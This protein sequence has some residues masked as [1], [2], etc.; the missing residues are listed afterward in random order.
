MRPPNTSSLR[1]TVPTF[2]FSL[3]TT[4]GCIW[5]SAWHPS[6]KL[7]LRDLQLLERHR[8][9]DDH[10]ALRRARDAA[11]DDQEVVLRI[12][13][14]DLQVVNR[15]ALAA[16]AAGGAHALDHPRRERRRANRT[17]RAVKHRPVGRC[18]AGEVM[19]LDHAWKPL[20]AAGADDVGALAV[21]EDR[22]QH[23][24]ADLGLVGA[25]RQRHFSLGLRVDAL[26]AFADVS[27][28]RLVRLRRG[29]LDEAEL[30]RFVAVRLR[31]LGLDDD[32]RTSL[33]HG[34]RMNRAVRIEDLRHADFAADD[35]CHRR[36]ST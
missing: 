22:R 25:R 19:P 6:S 35:S 26:M 8:L 27:G 21:G 4:P 7:D 1:S 12:D 24:I 17:R 3:F 15:D 23:L 14:Q 29:L 16:H 32:T 36:C 11:L 30:H 2:L 20:A 31:A 5:V 28:G 13:A 34:G 9:A 33:D 18:A 10:V